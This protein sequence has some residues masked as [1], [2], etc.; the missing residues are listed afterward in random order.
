MSL[1]IG[2][3]TPEGLV[4]AGES[5][6]TQV[7]NGINRVASDNAVKVFELSKSVLVATAGWAFMQPTGATMQ[8]NIASLMEELKPAIPPDATVQQIAAIVHTRF[9]EIYQQHTTQLPGTAV[10]AGESALEFIVAGYDP[11]T[12]NGSLFSVSIPSEN[13]PGVPNR[14]NN[15][16][17]PWWIGQVDVVARLINGYDPR[18]FTLNL[19]QAAGGV[20]GG[21]AAQLAGLLYAVFYNTMTIQDAID[22]AISLIQV[23][24]NIQ[25]FTA[26][27][28]TQLGGVAGVGGPIDVAV[29]RPGGDVTWIA[30]KELHV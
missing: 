29:I 1:C 26:G 27:I 17:G 5:R 18:I 13:P 24:I 8:K 12:T 2:V 25:K 23:T 9:N 19:A 21:A 10:A 6:Q 30:R 22:F 15:Q 28:A 20:A 14:T 7:I 16:P 3:V 4:V 11:G